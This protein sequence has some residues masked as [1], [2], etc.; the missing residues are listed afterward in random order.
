MTNYMMLHNITSQM[1]IRTLIIITTYS[2]FFVRNSSNIKGQEIIIIHLYYF[3]ITGKLFNLK[4]YHVVSEDTFLKRTL[5]C[6]IWFMIIIWSRS[7]LKKTCHA[8][9]FNQEKS[10]AFNYE[11]NGHG[12]PSLLFIIIWLFLGNVSLNIFQ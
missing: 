5:S 12:G 2:N 1:P 10:E 6:R 7:G 3:L 8:T 11:W 9:N 4:K